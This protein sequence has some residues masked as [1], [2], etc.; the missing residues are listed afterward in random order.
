MSFPHNSASPNKLVIPFVFWRDWMIGRLWWDGSR[1]RYPHPVM[2]WLAIPLV[3]LTL[4]VL[5][6]EFRP[7]SAL[8]NAAYALQGASFAV[9]AITALVWW[10]RAAKAGPLHGDDLERAPRRAIFVGL[11]LFAIWAA[12]AIYVFVIT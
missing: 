4:G 5:M 1:V 9:G 10:R 11:A 12:T 7:N 8:A 2:R 6:D 3:W